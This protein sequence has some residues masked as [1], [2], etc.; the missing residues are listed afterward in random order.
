LTAR[1]VPVREGSLVV[2][3]SSFKRGRVVGVKGDVVYVELDNA[4]KYL[5]GVPVPY[6][7]LELD[8]VETVGP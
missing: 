4:P 6:D 5:E 8:V 7:R 3:K 2:V 1:R